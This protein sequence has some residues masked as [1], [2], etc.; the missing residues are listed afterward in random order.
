MAVPLLQ[1]TPYITSMA[2]TTAEGAGERGLLVQFLH[3]PGTNQTC[4]CSRF[5]ATLTLLYSKQPIKTWA[6]ASLFKPQT[7]KE[8]PRM[9]E[10]LLGPI[11]PHTRIPNLGSKLI[12]ME[13]PQGW[14]RVQASILGDS[15]SNLS[16]NRVGRGPT[17]SDFLVERFQGF[18]FWV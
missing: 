10:G 15:Y 18:G 5:P 8:G 17:E 14:F 3:A 4:T 2:T 7:P 9:G 11:R 13:S 6:G 12:K 1:R 16:M